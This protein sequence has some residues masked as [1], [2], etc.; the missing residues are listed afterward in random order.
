MNMILVIADLCFVLKEECPPFPTQN[1]S[2]SVKDAYDRWT[3]ANDKAHFYI[4]AIISD[5]LS[6]KHE[7]IETNFFKQLKEDEMALKVGTEDVYS[8]RT[9]YMIEHE[10]QSQLSAPGT[11]QQNGVSERRNRTLLDM[12]RSMMSYAQLSSSFWAR[13]VHNPR[14]GAKSLQVESI[15]LWVEASI[16]ILKHGFDQNIDEPRVYKKINK[17]Q[18]QMKDLREAQYVLGIQIIRDPKNKMLALSQATYI[19]K[20]LVRYSMQN[21]KKDLLPF[22][23]KVHLS[24]EQ[25]PKTP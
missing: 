18:F 3:K 17:A 19:D 11:P 6:K 13:G 5:I 24:K 23:H 2:E 14:L 25:C 21:S 9:D 7:I 15:H 22:R 16:W 8:A 20:M 4:L 1:A 12:V 10:I